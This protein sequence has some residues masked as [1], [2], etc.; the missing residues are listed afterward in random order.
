MRVGPHAH[1][2]CPPHARL[3]ACQRPPPPLELTLLVDGVC[4]LGVQ[5]PQAQQVPAVVPALAWAQGGDQ[6]VAR[7]GRGKGMQQLLRPALG[8]LRT[9]PAQAPAAAA[10][11]LAGAGWSP[12]PTTTHTH[13]HTCT[14][15]LTTHHPPPAA[16]T[17]LSTKAVRV[18]SWLQLCSSWMSPG[19]RSYDMCSASAASL[20]A[21][22]ASC[23]ASVRRSTS[24]KA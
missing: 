21:A 7:G 12:P 8:C 15:T 1:P 11:D 19:C 17:S 3:S 10:L 9:C 2:I 22:S 20:I 6:R 23:C 13:T 5:R 16:P 4:R 24:G 18:C 14:P